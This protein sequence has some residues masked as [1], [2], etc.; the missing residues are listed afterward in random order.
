MTKI[1][2]VVMIWRYMN[3]FYK[4]KR[5]TWGGREVTN[6]RLFVATFQISF[7]RRYCSN[8]SSLIT[9]YL[10]TEAVTMATQK[11]SVTP[12]CLMFLNSF[13]S[14]L[15]NWYKL[16]SYLHIC[17]SFL[18]WFVWRFNKQTFS[19]NNFTVR[20][21]RVKYPWHLEVS[22]PVT[23]TCFQ[24]RRRLKWPRALPAASSSTACFCEHVPRNYI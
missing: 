19:W 24:S 23:L 18:S 7:Q 10:L 9:F 6:Q 11:T 12:C 17:V 13:W 2:Y 22:S 20:L 4:C 16:N 5:E 21:S 14:K 1:T 3:Y 8:E 15:Q